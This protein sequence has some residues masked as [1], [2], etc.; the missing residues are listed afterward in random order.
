MRDPTFL[1]GFEHQARLE[2]ATACLE[3]RDS[4]IELLMHSQGTGLAS[5]L[6]RVLPT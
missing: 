3:G 2:L 1:R 6:S 4:T 5:Q